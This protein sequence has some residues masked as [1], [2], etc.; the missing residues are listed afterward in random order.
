MHRESGITD[1]FTMGCPTCGPDAIR[2][3]DGEMVPHGCD[4]VPPSVVVDCSSRPSTTSG[5][6]E[7]GHGE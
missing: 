6:V 3:E 2:Y 7:E 1:W 4:Y 5:S